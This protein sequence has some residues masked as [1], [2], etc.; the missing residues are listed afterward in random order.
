MAELRRFS[1][2]L[3]ELDASSR[4]V[5]AASK[6]V[7]F[8]LR[9]ATTNGTHT[10]PDQTI[11]VYAGALRFSD[12]DKCV[13]EGD[14]TVFFTVNGTPSD[15]TILPI[16]ETGV[17]ISDGTRIIN[18]GA[19]TG[20][21][22]PNY[23]GADTILGIFSVPSNGGT[24]ISNNIV[25]TDANGEFEAYVDSDIVDITVLD[26]NGKITASAVTLADVFAGDP[27]ATHDHSDSSGQT[28]LAAL[29]RWRTAQHLVNADLTSTTA[30]AENGIMAFDQAATITS[31]V[32]IPDDALTANDTN[33]ATISFKQ[34]ASNG[35]LNGSV[36]STSTATFGTGNWT[37]FSPVTLSPSLSSTYASFEAGE[38]LTWQITK[39]GSG[40]T[41][42]R[43][44]LI[45]HYTV[46]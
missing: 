26:A 44:M 21:S 28:R 37:A 19:D 34:R 32:Y 23:D 46:D 31:I 12:G 16:V 22:T 29:D 4:F 27:S 15:D 14:E 1:E 38:V 42:P 2:T 33:F 39:S 30:F 13:I 36:D 43:G 18:L 17:S 6:D 3:F 20:V 8:T 25:T 24:P 7:L 41:V 11:A 5:P 10:A 40:V 9:G 45:V 35:S